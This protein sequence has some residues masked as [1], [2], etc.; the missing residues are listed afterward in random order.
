MSCF[1]CLT[2]ASGKWLLKG[3]EIDAAG[4]YKVAGS[5]YLM[6][7][8]DSEMWKGIAG[9]ALEGAADYGLRLAIELGF[10]LTYGKPKETAHG[11]TH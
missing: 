11:D 1:S 3:V 9:P 7:L 2:Q 5:S 8:V 4:K 10:V 6:G